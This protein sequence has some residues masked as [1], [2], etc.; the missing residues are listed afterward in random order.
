MNR[1]KSSW[2][3]VVSGVSQ[4]QYWGWPCIID[5]LNKGIEC[6]SSKFVNDTKLGGIVDLPET[7]KTTVG[8]EQADHWAEANCMSFNKTKCC[9]LHIGHNN[10]MQCYRLGVEW[11]E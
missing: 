1:V 10:P 7:R 6:T 8:S 9:V 3:L 2:Q 11:L 5:G 4:G